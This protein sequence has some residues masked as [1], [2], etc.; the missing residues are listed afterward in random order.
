[1]I[2]AG[3][4]GIASARRAA[5]FGIKDAVVE[6]GRLGGTCVNVGCVP[7]KVMFSAAAIREIMVHDA[8]ADYGFD[9]SN[10]TFS[11]PKLKAA[12]DAYIKRLNG[13]YETNLGKSQV[14]ILH[15]RAKFVSPT[16]VEVGDQVY[17][18]DHIMI[19][20][21]G[22]PSTAGYPGEVHVINSDGFFE[23]EDLPAKSLV[24]GA[25]YIAVEMAGI[26]NALGSQTTLVIRHDKVLR[27]FDCTL[28]EHLTQEIK[29]SGINLVTNSGVDSVVKTP[30][31]LLDVKLKSGTTEQGFNIVLSAIGRVPN[32]D[33]LDLDKAGVQ[34][35]KS[36]FIVVDEYQNTN[37]KNVYA[38]GDVC[39]KWLLTPVAIAAGRRLSHRLF[40]GEK[41]LKLDYDDIPTVV[42]SH[43]P[44][45][46][47][48]LTEQE[49]TAKY[50][51]DDIKV[52]KSTFTNMFFAMSSRKEKTV[53]KLVC[54][55]SLNEKVVGLHMIGLACDEMLQGFAVAIK[56]GATKADFD[57]TVAIH[58]TGAEELVTMR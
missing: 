24:V 33:L 38:L 43:P 46:T 9:Y 54:V 26:L 57:R 15:G 41:D 4:G 48:G 44:I 20:C 5:E 18:A 3:S 31:G 13:I 23:L 1:V 42:F 27:N 53:M 56:M 29:N 35:D 36:G 6:E 58:P 40:N 32:T 14:D 45:G 34:T 50:G 10:L 17:S 22:R 11:W 52:Y 19:A 49:A 2:G 28:S 47:V 51:E 30:N 37:V 39:G 12:R 55:K 25:G 7:K 8:K 16:Q 21:G